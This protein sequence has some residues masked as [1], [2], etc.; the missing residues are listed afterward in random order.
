MR[1]RLAVLMLLAMLSKTHVLA[2]PVPN[3][4]PDPYAILEIGPPPE[5]WTAEQNLN[6]QIKFMT[7]LDI[8]DKV[9]SNP[10]VKKLPLV[11]SM[12]LKDISPWLAKNVRVTPEE[13]SRRLRFTF[14]AGKRPD[15]VTI[16][17]ALLGVN[18]SGKWEFIESHEKKLRRCEHLISTLESRNTTDNDRET[19]H[20]LRTIEIPGL[21]AEIARLKQ[22]KVIR[23][24]K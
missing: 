13:G 23:W 5:G 15:Q 1:Y 22:T 4:A 14:R 11:A 2:A 20:G 18:L 6:N 10:E 21:H 9:H 12:K 17:N 24:A 3:P 16:I 8:L 19:I 7:A